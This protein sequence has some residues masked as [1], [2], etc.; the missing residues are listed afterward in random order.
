MSNI[1]TV[2]VVY[3]GAKPVKHDN[4]LRRP[5]L[6][7]PGYGT[8]RAVPPADAEVYFRFPSVWVNEE[9]FSV[10]TAT[11]AAQPPREVQNGGA[12]TNAGSGAAGGDGGGL[13]DGIDRDIMIQAAILQL[14]PKKKGKDG[15]YTL[16]GRPRVD[17]VVA[18]IGTNVSAEEIDS[19]I[20][21]L[22][23]AGKL[24]G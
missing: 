22:K 13:G 24:T 6:S 23:H 1:A 7:W 20:K 17:R 14:D 15:D 21:A 9:T 11:A 19:A 10:M 18:I 3:I 16:Q 5:N 2:K 12:K 4:V 8:A